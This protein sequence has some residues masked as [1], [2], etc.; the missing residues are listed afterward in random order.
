MTKKLRDIIYNKTQGRCAYCGELLVN[1]WQV[2]HIEPKVNFE[3]YYPGENVN[4]IKNLFPTCRIC[5]HYKRS[6]GL[7]AWREYMLLFHLRLKKLPKNTQVYETQKRKIYMQTIADKYKITI[8]KPFN[9]IFY[10]E[11]L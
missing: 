5:N 4:D 2:D 1:D 11:T 6:L 8:D 7:F 9:G 10:F 3:V